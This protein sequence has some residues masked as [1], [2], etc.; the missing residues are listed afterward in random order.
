MRYLLALTLTLCVSGAFA[1]K[2][3]EATLERYF[4]I[5]TSQDFSGIADLMATDSMMNLKKT[6]DDA[7]TFQAN[8]GVY[9]LQRRIFGKKVSLAEV[10]AATPEFYLDQLAG[11]ILQSA[12]TQHLVVDSRKILGRID[13]T[14]EMTHIVARLQMHQNEYQGSDI[15]VYSLVNEDGEWKLRF[16]ATIKQMVTMIESTAR[17]VR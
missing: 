5:L 8:H 4:T 1:E 10:K 17:Q 6:M 7:I 3:P 11:Q 14:E 16:P 2:T 15:L 12:R 13:E 9:R